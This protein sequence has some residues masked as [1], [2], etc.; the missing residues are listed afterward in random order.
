M[1]M[2]CIRIL[3]DCPKLPN[4]KWEHLNID[5][6]LYK[7]PTLLPYIAQYKMGGPQYENDL[8]KNPT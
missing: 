5:N 4:I 8:Y 7:N 1:K 6:N 3:L 2:I